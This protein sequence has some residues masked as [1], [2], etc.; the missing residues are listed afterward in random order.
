[1]DQHAADMNS[2]TAGDAHPAPPKRSFASRLFGY[3]IFISFALGP[4]PRGT[5]SYAS[6]LAR[7]LRERDFAVF[8]SEDEAP[9][10]EHLDST[11]RNAL[12]RSKILVVIANR[13][14]LQRPG[15]VQMEVDEFRRRHPTRPVIPISVDGALQ[16]PH[17]ADGAQSWLVFQDKI[18]LDETGA[19]A[20]DGIATEAVVDR[21]AMAPM[22]ARSNVSWR[23][24]VRG[25]IGMLAALA[26]GLAAQTWN[27]NE[28]ARRA[29]ESAERARAELRRAVSLRLLAETQAILSGARADSHER[30]LLQLVA[31]GR[32]AR[33]A[34]VD[35]GSLSTLLQLEHLRKLIVAGV[36]VTA[37][38]FSAD[39]QRVVT[40]GVDGSLRAWS[41]STGEAIGAPLQAH[42]DMVSGIA[43]SPDGRRF[44]SASDDQT[45]RQWDTSS[46]QTLGPPLRLGE[47][48]L[49]SVAYSPD[50]SQLVAGDASGALHLWDARSGQPAAT[51]QGDGD[52]GISCV[53]FSPD[54]KRIVA[55][56]N[57][58]RLRLWDVA[59]RKARASLQHGEKSGVTSV[60]FSPDGSRIISGHRDHMLRVWDARTGQAIGKPLMGHEDELSGVAVSPDG[61]LIVSASGGAA[62]R[63]AAGRGGV[64]SRLGFVRDRL[65]SRAVP[66]GKRPVESKDNSLRLWDATTG[67]A[68]GTP[69]R[70]HQGGVSSVAFSP[71][72]RYILS[73]S[74]DGTLRLWAVPGGQGLGLALPGHQGAVLSVAFSPD[75]SRV[76]SGS[77]DRT[78][79]LWDA[80]TGAP[81]GEPMRGHTESVA[82]VAF[83]PDNRYIVSAGGGVTGAVEEALGKTADQRQLRLWDART[84]QPVATRLRD[85][86]AAA[87]SI[88][89][90]PDGTRIATG[91]VDHALRLWDVRSGQ[92]VGQALKGHTNW[93]TSLAFSPDGHRIVSAGGGVMRPE[94]SLRLWDIQ[95]GAA[96]GAPLQGHE[97]GVWSVAFSPDGS[98]IVSGSEDET[99]RLWDAATGRALGPPLRGHQGV[100]AA[101]AFSADGHHIV[102]GSHDKTLRIWDAHGG[103]PVGAA[104]QGH[105]AGVTSVAVSPD[106]TRLVSGSFDHHLRMWPA[107]KVWP[108]ELCK[109][110]TRNMGRKQWSEWVSPEIDY[111]VQCPGLPIP[112]DKS[113][114][115]KEKP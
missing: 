97:R 65:I 82:T 17:L 106:G 62:S 12:H 93:V 112:P 113:D 48:R 33:S 63:T 104:L 35:D 89:F 103:Q 75:G 40:G 70:G 83:S 5:H 24:V 68:F 66:G 6:D 21:L 16:D 114:N 95:T 30:A 115:S 39:S 51:L 14:T 69:L 36:P 58:G 100:V 59:T 42:Q 23:W 61:K 19:A 41:V 15:W 11:L 52:G 7:R 74:W 1:M 28:N 20:D 56:D 109:K 32:I 50:G 57:G 22:R 80:R 47:E 9:P 38:A 90:S 10:G 3:D 31:A 99:L 34:Q 45:L 98:R 110:L 25:V 85:Q 18:W 37:A 86:P 76:V 96:I 53:A 44:A 91:G 13:G 78:L 26:V 46:V 102:S 88:A 27:A 55:G 4:P 71:D 105:A 108:D 87:M 107:P 64:V 60:A 2:A 29:N 111:V 43:F 79:R 73:G 67:H 92:P 72:G 94:K 77:D 81:I 84:G 101:V 49:S 8:F 54:G